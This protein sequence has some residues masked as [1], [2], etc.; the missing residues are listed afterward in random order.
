MYTPKI[1]EDLISRLYV[2]AKQRKTTMKALVDE[3]L[4]KALD[5]ISQDSGQRAQREQV[6]SS[7]QGRKR[8]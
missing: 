3:L 8:S 7:I 4:E 2:L 6:G 1:R 5:T